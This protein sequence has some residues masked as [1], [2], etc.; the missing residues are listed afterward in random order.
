M[1]RA[2][3]HPAVDARDVTDQLSST[4]EQ[5]KYTTVDNPAHAG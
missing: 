2:R 1:L 3:S 4:S 5:D